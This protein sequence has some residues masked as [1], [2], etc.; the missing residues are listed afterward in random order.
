MT[1]KIQLQTV[2][3]ETVIQRIARNIAWYALR[4]A[5]PEY[6]SRYHLM[7]FSVVFL[8]DRERVKEIVAAKEAD[9]GDGVQVPARYVIFPGF[10]FV[11]RP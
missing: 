3:T 4:I 8:K 5:R 6:A 2:M 1:Q 9:R 10:L 7:P 11:R